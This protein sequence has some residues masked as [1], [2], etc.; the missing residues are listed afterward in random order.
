MIYNLVKQIYLGAVKYIITAIKVYN[1]FGIQTENA[2][3]NV[4]F[5]AN[6]VENLINSI[7]EKLNKSPIPILIPNPP[8]TLRTDKANPIIVKI[9]VAKGAEILEYF[10]ISLLT[11]AEVPDSLCS[12]M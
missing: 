5:N 2:A 4:P 9:N 3:L 8:R 10:S 6:T 12:S 11:T 1:I 7:Y